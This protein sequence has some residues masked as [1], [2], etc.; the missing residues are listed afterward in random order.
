MRE[1][2]LSRIRRHRKP[3]AERNV[4]SQRLWERLHGVL[5]PVRLC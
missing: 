2:I 5:E 4:D 3:K 1:S